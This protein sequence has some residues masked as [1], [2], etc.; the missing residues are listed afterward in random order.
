M[1]ALAVAGGGDEGD[2]PAGRN[3]MREMLGPHHVDHL[4]RQAISMCW[5]VLPTEKRNAETV[6][7]RDSPTGRAGLA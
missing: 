7:A 6:D 2:G 1:A 3:Q 5:M 4:I